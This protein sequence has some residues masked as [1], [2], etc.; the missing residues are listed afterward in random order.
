MTHYRQAYPVYF[1]KSGQ[2]LRYSGIQ[3]S[4]TRIAEAQQRCDALSEQFDPSS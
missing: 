4:P 2:R 1:L 3:W